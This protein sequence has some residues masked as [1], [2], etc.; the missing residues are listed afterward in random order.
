MNTTL[1]G[2]SVL[3]TVLLEL[4]KKLGWVSDGLGGKISLIGNAAI[5]GI[6]IFAGQLGYDLSSY[7]AAALTTSNLVTQFVVLFG[8]SWFTWKGLKVSGLSA[9]PD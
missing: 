9:R 4:A 3:L 8:T 5:V 2:F 7:D 1:T 6:G